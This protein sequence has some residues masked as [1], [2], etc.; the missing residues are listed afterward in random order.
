MIKSEV[1][2]PDLTDKIADQEYMRSRWKSG[3]LGWLSYLTD[4]TLRGYDRPVDWNSIWMLE[5]SGEGKLIC[6]I[7]SGLIVLIGDEISIL[8]LMTEGHSDDEIS[9][10]LKIKSHESIAVRQKL[11]YHLGV[12]NN[13]DLISLASKNNL[14]RTKIS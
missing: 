12:K 6:G 14:F 13:I 1:H 2:V 3:F 9:T 10:I 8:I 11:S 4:H 7:D 5:L